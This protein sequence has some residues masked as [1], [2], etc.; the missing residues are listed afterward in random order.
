MYKILIADDEPHVVSLLQDYFELNQYQVITAHS[1]VEAVEASAKK[2]DIILLDINM[3]EMDGIEVCRR[4][5]SYVTCPILFLTARIE[6][7]DKVTGF[8]AGADDYIIKPFSLDELGARVAAHIRRDHRDS[9]QHSVLVCGDLTID[10]STMTVMAG[11]NIIELA[12][13]EYQ[14]MELLSLYPGQIFDKERIYERIWGY[15]AEGDSTVVAEHI[16]RLRAKLGRFYEA[17][18]IETVWGMGYKWVL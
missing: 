17:E 5:R 10:Y 15:D 7:A 16:R 3:P 12:K 11:G 8:A 13:K 9:A 18:H 2:P 1:G 4:I 6:D 14:I